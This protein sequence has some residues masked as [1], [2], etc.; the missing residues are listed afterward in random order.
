MS[1]DETFEG[2]FQNP[3]MVYADILNKEIE[4]GN[5]EYKLKLINLNDEQITHRVTQL[6]WRLNESK[7]STVNSGIDLTCETAFT[8]KKSIS[9]SPSSS[10]ST[11]KT[12]NSITGGDDK[13]CAVY[14]IGVEDSGYPIGISKDELKESIN[15]LLKIAAAANGELVIKSILKGHGSD[16]SLSDNNY[17]A[18]VLVKRTCKKQIASHSQITVAIAG[19]FDSGKSTLIGVLSTGHHDNGKGSARMH[20]FQHNHE[21]SSGR[22]SSIAQHNIYFDAQG[23]VLNNSI[24]RSSSSVTSKTNKVSA[25]KSSLLKNLTEAEMTDCA[26]CVT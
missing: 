11:S 10:S 3:L 26:R 6:H 7:E 15:S 14:F 24:S 18:K 8:P 21:L 2:F 1:D 9:E 4:E 13:D 22:T 20:I 17:V 23:N 25:S 12:K 16:R 19:D 5:I